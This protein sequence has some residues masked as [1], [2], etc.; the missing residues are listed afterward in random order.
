[1][2]SAKI[3]NISPKRITGWA[4]NKKQPSKRIEVELFING[5]LIAKTICSLPRPYLASSVAHPDRKCGFR[6]ELKSALAFQDQIEVKCNGESL[7]L[8][9]N[10]F[11]YRDNSRKILILGISKSGTS[12]LFEKIRTSFRSA[13]TFFE[14]GGVNGITNYSLHKEIVEHDEVITKSIIQPNRAYDLDLLDQLYGKVILIYRDPRDNLISSFLYR[15]YHGHKPN[16]FEFNN[17]YELLKIKSGDRNFPTYK[18]INSAMDS[19][20]F[21]QIKHKLLNKVI[22]KN[23]VFKLKYEDLIENKLDGLNAFLEIKVSE[24]FKVARHLKRVQRSK[25]SGNWRRWFTEE[26]VKFYKPIINPV[27]RKL[28]YDANDWEIDLSKN[29]DPKT[30]LDYMSN[31]FHGKLR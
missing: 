20:N 30:T 29:I 5:L 4:F 15:W 24:S 1:M 21:I 14:P 7:E 26:D 18:V 13:K 23:S 28:D 27:L 16:E 9:N 11:L 10:P 22:A 2:I 8:P 17:A 25:T 12:L 6:F 19:K 31:L 3:A